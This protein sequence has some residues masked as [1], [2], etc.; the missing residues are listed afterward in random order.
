MILG[1]IRNLGQ[2]RRP[3]WVGKGRRFMSAVTKVTIL[4]LWWEIYI[5]V[6]HTI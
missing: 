4:Q 1:V 6:L 2:Q 3:A 5:Y